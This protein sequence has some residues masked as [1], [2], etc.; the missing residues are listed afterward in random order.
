MSWE[1][2]EHSRAPVSDVWALLADARGWSKWARFSSSKLEREGSPTPDGVGALRMFGTGPVHSHEEVVAFEPP[3]RFAYVL[4]KGL[5]LDGY[6]ADVRLESDNG[7][8]KITW[9]SSFAQ[10]RPAFTSGFYRWF[11]RT[12]IRDTARRLARAAE[13]RAVG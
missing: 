1:V 9:A 4:R 13:H 11:L 7:G 10:A 8:T 3:T 6:R 5:P 2:V 12:F